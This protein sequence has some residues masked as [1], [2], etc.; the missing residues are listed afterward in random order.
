MKKNFRGVFTVMITPTRVDGSVS[1]DGMRDFT[2]WQ[3]RQGIHGLIPLGSTGE[4]LSLSDADRRSVAR[5][6]IE[7]AKCRVPVL[8]GTGHEDTREV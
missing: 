7:T 2:E 1:L 5:T 4:F 3:I 8:I 6:V